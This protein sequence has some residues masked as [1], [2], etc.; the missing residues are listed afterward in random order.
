[1]VRQKPQVGALKK[2]P[3][4]EVAQFHKK[5]IRVLK[6]TSPRPNPEVGNMLKSSQT[7]SI[8]RLISDKCPLTR[9]EF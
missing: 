3:W 6:G 5:Q 8:M 4:G 9:W 1:M 7:P 2:L